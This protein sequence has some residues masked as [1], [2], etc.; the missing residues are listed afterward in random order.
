M[1]NCRNTDTVDSGSKVAGSASNTDP[2]AV[3]QKT[4]VTEKE[5]EI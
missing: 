4:R 3:K 5:V 1:E 2:V